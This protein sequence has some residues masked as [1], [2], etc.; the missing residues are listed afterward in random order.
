MVVQFPLDMVGNITDKEDLAERV[1]QEVW[2]QPEVRELPGMR[3]LCFGI[4]VPNTSGTKPTIP[5]LCT[6]LGKLKERY[7]TRGGYLPKKNGLF[8]FSLPEDS[9]PSKDRK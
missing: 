9:R 3:E 7:A 2:V 1:A 4:P 6:I 8:A 5:N